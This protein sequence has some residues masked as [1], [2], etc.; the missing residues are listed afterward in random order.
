MNNYILP[1]CHFK[2]D[3]F[4]QTP[5]IACTIARE[6]VYMFGPQAFRA[7]IGITI[8]FDKI[9]AVFAL[10][11]LDFFGKFSR[12]SFKIQKNAGLVNNSF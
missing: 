1:F 7:M 4:H 9:A 2:R 10:K 8:P 6:N 12:H 3:G 11:V 5:A